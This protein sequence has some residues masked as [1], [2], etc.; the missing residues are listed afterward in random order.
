M[1]LVEAVV[2]PVVVTMGFTLCHLEW[3][4]SSGKRIL[5]VFLDH[6]RGVTLDD[7]AKLNR[8]LGSALDAAEAVPEAVDLGKVLGGPYILEVSSPGI[9]RP[10]SRRSQFDR[11]LGQRVTVRTHGALVEG[12]KQRTFHGQIAATEPDPARP[13]DDRDGFVLVDGDGGDKHRFS[14]AQIRRANLV[15]EG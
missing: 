4:G 8:I 13:D 10:L 7:C 12:S 2:E 9:E 11:F 1:R 5:R 14:L 3:A 15:Y 6:E